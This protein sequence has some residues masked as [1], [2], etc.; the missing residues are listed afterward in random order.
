MWLPLDSTRAL[1]LHVAALQALCAPLDSTRHKA[2][3]ESRTKQ[4]ANMMDVT[5]DREQ[6]QGKGETGSGHERRKEVGQV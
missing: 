2:G 3:M 5:R 1:P 6:Q 4:G